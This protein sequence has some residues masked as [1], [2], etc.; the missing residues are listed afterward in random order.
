MDILNA[1]ALSMAVVALVATPRKGRRQVLPSLAV[2][3]IFLAFG[4]T[5]GPARFP[6]WLPRPLTSY[7]GGQRPMAWF[8]L[9]PWGAWALVGVAVGH[10]WA[11][12]SRNAAAQIRAFA[13][14][15]TAGAT[16]VL[17]VVTVRAINP[18]VIRYPSELVMQ[19][20][21]G[22]FFHRLGLIGILAG[23]GFFWCR[24]RGTRFSVMRQLGRTSLL[25]YW[26][27]IELCYGS[28]VYVLRSRL[29]L[30]TAALAV[31]L[32]TSAMLALSLAKT[33]YGPAF[34]QWLR[35]R[36]RSVR[37]A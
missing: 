5:I 8:P 28:I 32:L 27:H 18:T 10:A 35:A 17:A 14:T 9:F 24:G 37:P 29:S 33:Q 34:A 12:S 4:T 19:M 13:F 36:F 1:I 16:L 6:D 11:M 26:V 3:A 25:V 22:I 7:I 21:P 2:A 15:F 30:G 23:L 20:G 31:V